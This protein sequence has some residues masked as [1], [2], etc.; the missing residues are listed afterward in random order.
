MISP[1]RERAEEST[2]PHE[3]NPL[4]YSRFS[5]SRRPPDPHWDLALSGPRM[6]LS[7]RGQD[8]ASSSG[9]NLNR[10]VADIEDIIAA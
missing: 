3:Y 7:Q 8:G 4:V 2:D 1:L 9:L 6:N 10:Q 5:E